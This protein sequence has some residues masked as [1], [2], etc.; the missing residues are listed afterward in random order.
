MAAAVAMTKPREAGANE[1]QPVGRRPFLGDERFVDDRIAGAPLHCGFE[2]VVPIERAVALELRGVGDDRQLLRRQ[3]RQ[4]RRFAQVN[5]QAV[6]AVEALNVET[7]RVGS[8]HEV[9]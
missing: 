7:Q 8:P 3:V 1:N 5:E 4:Q 2:R 9:A 6:L